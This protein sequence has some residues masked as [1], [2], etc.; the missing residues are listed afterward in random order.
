[1][2]K[3]VA[4]WER[5]APGS[6]FRDDVDHVVVELL[7][8][9]PSSS[10]TPSSPTIWRRPVGVTDQCSSPDLANTPTQIACGWRLYGDFAWLRH[11]SGSVVTI[12]L[13]NGQ[14]G[15]DGHLLTPPLYIA[16]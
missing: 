2:P 7:G 10:G 14:V 6:R 4:I 1:M 5:S 11:L 8:G 15:V 12:D 16:S 13:L 9:T 3:S